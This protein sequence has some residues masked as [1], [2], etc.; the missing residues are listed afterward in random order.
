[1]DG[2]DGVGAV[3]GLFCSGCERVNV[4]HNCARLYLTYTRINPGERS[5]E[6]RE[7]GSRDLAFQLGTAV[8]LVLASWQFQIQSIMYAYRT[9]VL[10][11]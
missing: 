11:I 4:L 7:T 6:R 3:E 2:S 1:M 10:I 9:I 5:P 8:V